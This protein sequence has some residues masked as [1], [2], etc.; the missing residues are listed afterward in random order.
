VTDPL[1][2]PEFLAGLRPVPS[3]LDG[4][5]PSWPAADLVGV[6]PDGTPLSVDLSSASRPV[7]LVFLTTDCDGCNHFWKGLAD[8]PPDIDIVV[9]TKGPD[10]VASTDVAGLA[11]GLAQ[12]PVLMSDAAWSDYRVTGYPFLVLVEPGTRRILGESVGFG[13]S[14]VDALLASS[15]TDGRRGRLG[16]SEPGESSESSEPG[17]AG[18]PGNP[19][20]R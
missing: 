9:V 16:R 10:V 14:D 8:P 3:G 20:D 19:G 6:C 11:V 17:D 1:S 4:S 15:A 13:W 18:E 12:L 5:A 7:L 2:D